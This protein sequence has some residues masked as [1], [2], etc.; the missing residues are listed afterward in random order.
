MGYVLIDSHF[1]DHPK[2]V[3][4]GPRAMWLYIFAL[5]HVSRHQA[6]DLFPWTGLEEAGRKESRGSLLAACKLVD[7][8][9]WERVDGG[10]RILKDDLLKWRIC[11]GTGIQDGRKRVAYRRWREAVK[12]RDRYTCLSCGASD[13]EV[14]AHHVRPWATTPEGRFDIGNGATLCVPCHMEVHYGVAPDD[15]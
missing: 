13:R 4:A 9:L 12:E 10:Y 11:K 2:I 1:Y 8:G 6:G 7:V 5:C 15:A 3:R 14:V